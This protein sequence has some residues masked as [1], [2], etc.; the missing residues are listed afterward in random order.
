MNLLGLNVPLPAS[1]RSPFA[2][3]KAVVMKEFVQ[4]R[5]DR[6]T[7]GMMII[8]PLLQLMI[9]GYAINMDPKHL[10]AV[11]IAEDQGRFTRAIVAAMENSGYY[12]FKG[13]LSDPAEGERMLKSGGASFVVTIPVNFSRDLLRGD[14]PQ[15]LI[16]A[17]AS[18]PSSSSNA[19]GQA[20]SIILFALRNELKTMRGETGNMLIEP[21]AGQPV[22]IVIHR[23]YNPEGRSQLSIVP[24]VIGVIL[25]MTMLMLTS[26]SMTRESESGT[27]ENLLAMPAQPI[28][29]MIGKLTPYILVGAVQTIIALAAA[30]FLFHVPFAGNPFVLLLGLTG[31]IVSNL[32]LGFVVSTLARTQ[33][34]AIQMSFFILLPS[35][36]L[37]G[38]AFP[39][40]GMPHWAQFLGEALPITHFL[41]II[42]G[43][44]LK[45][46]GIADLA[47]DFFALLLI[48]IA[49]A[50]V[51]MLRYRRTLD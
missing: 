11:V 46:A 15:L 16:A 43:V 23:Q 39:F 1:L 13:A 34:Q 2:R 38:F 33:M 40:R 20:Q 21:M 17:D 6:L 4:V 50:S 22:D 27:L 36:L 45:S 14:Q 5:R 7:L 37:S 29:V 30:L 32:S 47:G 51:A 35:I 41:R 3:I 10:P 49:L 28:E 8:M 42:R 19:I 44:M 24:G 31:F 26:V 25:T 18:D 12:E 48:T 9:F